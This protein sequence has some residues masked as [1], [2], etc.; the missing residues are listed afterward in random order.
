MCRHILQFHSDSDG[1]AAGFTFTALAH[2]LGCGGSLHGQSGNI[3][4]P[5][6]GDGE[7]YPDSTECIWEVQAPM[8]FHVVFT[9]YGR[10]DVE[11]AEDCANDNVQVGDANRYNIRGARQ[12]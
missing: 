4:F 2:G 6:S 1:V 12:I 8:G 5:A 9:F 11:T 10:F 3:T 7:N